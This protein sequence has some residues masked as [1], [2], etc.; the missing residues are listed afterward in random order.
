MATT[1]KERLDEIAQVLE[2]IMEG[3]SVRGACEAVG[4]SRSV[5]QARVDKEQYAWAR[6]QQA[7]VNFDDLHDVA[8]DVRLGR[9][10]PQAGKVAADIIKWRLARMRPQVYGDK[11]A[12]EHSGK[13]GG[14]IQVADLSTMTD[15]QLQIILGGKKGD[16]SE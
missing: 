8:D 15:E 16:E 10:G 6:R 5:F 11:V 4:I 1:S 13:D 7:D 2:L 9:L 3:S 14:P 12:L